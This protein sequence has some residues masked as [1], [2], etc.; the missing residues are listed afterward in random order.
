MTREEIL[1]VYAQGPEAVVAL[2][3]MLLERLVHVEARLAAVEA[4]LAKDSHNSGKPPSSDPVRRPRKQ[5]R[6][7][8]DALRDLFAGHPFLPAVPEQSP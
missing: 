8:L 1:A 5:D 6:T 7:A 4:H 3:T 2:V